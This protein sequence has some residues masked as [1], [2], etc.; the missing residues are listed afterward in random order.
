MDYWNTFIWKQNELGM[1]TRL[2]LQE[3]IVFKKS[4]L[5]LDTTTIRFPID[6]NFY[7]TIVLNELCNVNEINH[8]NEWKW[9]RNK[10]NRTLCSST[11]NGRKV[12]FFLKKFPYIIRTQKTNRF[13]NDP[14]KTPYINN[15]NDSSWTW[16]M[17]FEPH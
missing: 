3:P 10:P 8:R 5:Q 2:Q 6:L 9:S 12:V 11:P 4:V 17:T 14:R 7:V 1:H 15:T 13:M 16:Q